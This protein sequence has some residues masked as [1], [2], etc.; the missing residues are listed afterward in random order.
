MSLYSAS[1]NGSAAA[2]CSMCALYVAWRCA[3]CGG[4]RLGGKRMSI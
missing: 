3:R 1:L 4:G 2:A